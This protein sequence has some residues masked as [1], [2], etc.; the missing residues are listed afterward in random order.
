MH[1]RNYPAHDLE[2]LVVVFELKIWQHYLY[3]VHMDILFDHKCL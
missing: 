1:K 2:L 3:G